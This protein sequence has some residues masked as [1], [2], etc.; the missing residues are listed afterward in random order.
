[1]LG[2]TNCVGPMQRAYKNAVAKGHEA[3]VKLHD[4][5]F[6]LEVP[7]KDMRFRLYNNRGIAAYNV[8]KY[9]QAIFD[10]SVAI[11]LRGN[12]WRPLLLRSHAYHAIGDCRSAVK[13]VSAA[14]MAACLV[15]ESSHHSE[16]CHTAGSGG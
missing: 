11:S 1:M 16:G 14:V 10:A 9:L 15:T 6:M 12:R 7:E 4:V 13:A 5:V 8:G 3:A 2:L